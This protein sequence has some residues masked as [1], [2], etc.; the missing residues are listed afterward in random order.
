[1]KYEKTIEQIRSGTLTR[2]ALRTIRE[3]AVGALA[4]GDQDAGSVLRALDNAIARDW[5]IVFM[6]FC[7]NGELANR[8]DG[9][10]RAEGICTFDY[11]KSEVQMNQFRNIVAGDLIVL[12]KSE[13]H[14]K[15]MSLHGH[16]R[17]TG[18]RTGADGRRE[19]LLDWASAG[20]FPENVPMMGCQA[21][22]NL[23][24]MGTVE[25]AMPVQFFDWAG[26]FRLHEG[27][28]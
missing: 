19:L 12:K 1:M 23:R 10:W 22:V 3:R 9:R 13:V 21:T 18:T 17:V 14:G 27:A 24:E 11:D 15:L 26:L 4:T 2:E 25:G 16:G 6:G 28:G 8:V 20:P 7:P 5:R